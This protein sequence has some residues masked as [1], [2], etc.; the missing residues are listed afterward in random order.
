MFPIVELP[1][2]LRGQVAVKEIV[3]NYLVQVEYKFS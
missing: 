1:G 3:R 2:F